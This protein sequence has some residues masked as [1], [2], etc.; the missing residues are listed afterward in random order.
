MRRIFITGMSGTG[1]SSVIEALS[2]RGF[3]AIDTD[4]DD[5]CELSVIDGVSELV[6]REARMHK[7]L[8][9]P[10]TFP[11][12]VSGCRS[13]QGKFYRFFDYKILF[14]APLEV[15]L[16]RVA[17]R[18]TNPYG[19]SEQDRAEICHNFA[20]IQPLLQKSA[21][22]EIDTTTMRVDEIAD[23]LVGLALKEPVEATT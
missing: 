21:D 7:L 23:F 5:W 8:A 22:F 6:W 17:A 1:K 11:L 16:E 19:K 13:N 12:F 14:S 9:K 3:T 18:S 2:S 4:Y 10:L 20:G 15:I